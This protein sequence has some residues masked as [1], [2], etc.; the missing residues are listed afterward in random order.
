MDIRSLRYFTET[1]RLGSFTEAANTL[2]VT[3]S[4][5]SKMVRQLEDEVGEALLL[6]EIKGL[7]LTDIGS[8]VYNRGREILTALQQLEQEIRETQ[9]VARGTLAL[10]MPPMIN[11]LFTEVLKQFREKYPQIDLKL[12]ECTGQEVEH[13]VASGE[14]AAGMTVLPVEAREDIAIAKVTAHRV[15]A[16]AAQD[17]M[18]GTAD[19]VALRSLG[20]K[21][22]ILLNDDF[23][24]TRLLRRHFARAGIEPQIGAQSGQ[25][26]W[27]VAM[28]RAGMG[29]ALLPE[30]F[31]QRIN[32]EGLTCKPISQPAIWWEIALLWNKRRVSHALNAWLDVCRNV[33]GGE[34]PDPDEQ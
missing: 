8:V 26:D 18:T 14:L 6:R 30:P 25:W 33:L 22:L 28:A 10:G 1:I 2:G 34:W 27:T 24:L 15:W 17:E 4:T 3:Q 21:P 23:A 32:V 12:H 20:Q 11:L 16:I 9:S 19:T 13:R 7:A 31:V 29:I 5:I